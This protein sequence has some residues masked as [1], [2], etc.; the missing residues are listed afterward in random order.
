MNILSKTTPKVLALLV[1]LQILVIA[2]SNYL[3]QIPVSFD[4]SAY[5]ADLPE[6]IQKLDTTWG[7]FTFPFVF[8]LTDLT[9]RIL[10][11]DSARKV[12]FITMIPALLISY[13]FSNVFDGQGN[14][15]GLAGM[16]QFNM[17]VF[18]IVIAS[19]TAYVVGQLLDIFVFNR[20]RQ[21]PQWWAAPLASTLFG[22]I[23]DSIC[24]FT[25]AFYQSSDPFMAENWIEIG[26]IDYVFKLSI[27][28]VVFIP[29]YGILLNAIQR[30]LTKQVA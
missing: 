29:A 18:R 9:V 14:F 30:K 10:G 26:L 11:K 2:S 23:I 7:A 5:I 21:L 20:L 19:F 28:L 25:I 27:S 3:V 13:F 12:I 8:L 16:M 24:F 22:T 4:L 1:F 15:V 17:F 6:K